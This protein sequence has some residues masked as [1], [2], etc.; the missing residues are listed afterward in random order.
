MLKRVLAFFVTVA[1]IF[2]MYIHA[3]HAMVLR[4]GSRGTEVTRVQQRLIELEFLSTRATGVFGPATREAVVRFQRAN[5]LTSDGI[6]GRSTSSALFP[7]QTTVTPP[8]Q[9]ITAVLGEGSRGSEVTRIQ[10]RLIELG[11][12]N[13]RATGVF[14]PATKDAVVR[15]QRANNLTS[16]GVVGRTTLAML[17]PTTLPA[18]PPTNPITSTLRRGSRGAQVRALQNR[19]IEMGLLNATANGN[20]G[21]LTQSA[22]EQFQRSNGLTVNGIVDSITAQR[23]FS[24][25]QQTPSPAQ[26]EPTSPAQ[27]EPTPPAQPEPTTPVQ[28]EPTTP[29]QP[30]PTPPVQSEQAPPAQ[31]GPMVPAQPH[32]NSP[33][34]RF[35]GTPGALS[36]RTVIIDPGHGGSDPGAV[37]N[38][39]M[40]K[41]YVLDISL[42]LRRMLEE[43]G[44]IVLMTR[45][46]DVFRSLLFRSAFA[47]RHVLQLEIE[48]LQREAA[49]L[50]VQ[51]SPLPATPEP[52]PAGTN[53][54]LMQEL[55]GL[56]VESAQL[57]Q[58]QSDITAQIEVINEILNVWNALDEDNAQLKKAIEV[59]DNDAAS[60]ER[61][62][63]FQR[64]LQLTDLA[65]RIGLPGSTRDIANSSLLSR[66]TEITQL[67]NRINELS[68]QIAAAQRQLEKPAQ[69]LQPISATPQPGVPATVNNSTTEA[70]NTWGSKIAMFDRYINS[71][72]LESR[73]G[74]FALSRDSSNNVQANEMLSKVF[75]LTRERYQNDIVF[76]SVHIN[77]TTQIETNSSGIRMFYR[78]NGPT[79]AWGS[80][81]PHY[82]LNYNATARR[83]LAQNLLNSLNAFT[84]FHGEVALPS[85]MDF[86]VIRET[87]LVSSLIE[88]G[89]INN[90]GDRM[91]MQQE[92]LRED[93]AAGI[94][95]GLVNYF[96]SSR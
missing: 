93:A 89:F 26:P 18:N 82:Y 34:T 13:T 49:Q 47:N 21:P 92:Q 70:I 86:S 65:A 61:S 53:E 83:S 3:A 20:F 35:H 24:S 37:R 56:Q 30:E 63:I 43:A 46:T 81:N 57:R 1:V 28:P 36:G 84:A 16:D 54:Q 32:P 72:N 11:L 40:E 73:E 71:P 44:A 68:H 55:I 31:P 80:G 48:R 7:T 95:T 85:R 74:I 29:V 58:R 10:Q 5:G 78:H 23:L 39:V 75:D 6:V 96:N 87:N 2:T 15:F 22:V 45:E 52:E 62:Q 59:S 88:V 51:H 19:L 50:P 67:T 91:L 38:G 60:S 94:Y 79:F 9:S 33:F 69:I 90:P 4:E 41:T 66:Q 27:P 76:I 17:F 8:P 25:T 14:G 77:S 12:L 42:R 64:E